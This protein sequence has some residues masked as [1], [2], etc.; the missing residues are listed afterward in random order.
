M[1]PRGLYGGDLTQ[2]E[3]QHKVL[4]PNEGWRV[5]EHLALRH[6][7]R[8]WYQ[9]QQR[10][11]QD[12]TR[13]LCEGVLDTLQIGRPRIRCS[14]EPLLFRTQLPGCRRAFA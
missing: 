1:H 6:E 4:T 5:E 12:G 13:M 2:G 7:Q 11:A 8:A 14:A 10:T 9:Q 3:L